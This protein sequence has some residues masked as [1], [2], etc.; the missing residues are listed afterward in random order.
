MKK[1]QVLNF[2]GIMGVM[3][4]HGL[5][6]CRR[7]YIVS[8]VFIP[9]HIL[10]PNKKIHSKKSNKF[11]NRDGDTNSRKDFQTISTVLNFFNIVIKLDK[12]YTKLNNKFQPILMKI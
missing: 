2:I 12:I 3:L 9:S 11:L 4:I 8:Y 6:S 10:S 5:V 7:I 1:K